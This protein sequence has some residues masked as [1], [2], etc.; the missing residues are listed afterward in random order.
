MTT[1]SSS[2]AGCGEGGGISVG[3]AKKI[4]SGGL[5]GGCGSEDDVLA[6]RS[7]CLLDLVKA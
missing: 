7:V 4:S 3:E 5:S 2:P 1:P 6:A